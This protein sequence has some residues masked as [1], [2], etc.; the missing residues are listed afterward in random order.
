M[1]ARAMPRPQMPP[2]PRRQTTV[3]DIEAQVLRHV[4][5]DPARA[6]MIYRAAAEQVGRLVG[7][8]QNA[9]A[10]EEL[11]ALAQRFMQQSTSP[12]F[13]TSSDFDEQLHA[14]IEG[15]SL[16]APNDLELVAY[17][18][19]LDEAQATP[20]TSISPES[21][22]RDT[23]LGR[24]S[25]FKYA[26]TEQEHALGV[27]QEDTLVVW[28]G[29]KHEAQAFTVDFSLANPAPFPPVPDDPGTEPIYMARPYGFVE[30]G[31]DGAKTR[32]LFDIGFGT[33]FTVV[34]NY[35]A[36]GAGMYAPPEAVDD[37]P[38][39]LSATLRIGCSIGAFA[40]P[41]VSPVTF[42]GYVDRLANTFQS[43]PIQRPVKGTYLLPLLCD[44]GAGST[45]IDFLDFNAKLLYQVVWNGGTLAASPIPLS[46][47]VAYVQ[48]L[49]GTGDTANYR[50]VFQLAL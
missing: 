5:A 21:F 49:N 30:Y 31:S 18:Q 42:T 45:N 19:Q 6:P 3:G 37:D 35:I 15:Y 8:P 47:D 13:G 29:L 40:A 16:G 36:A 20:R 24:Y 7:D 12:P 41:S 1:S 28:P 4:Q 44:I 48:L 26:P 14:S 39:T 34:G 23:A 27:R 11:H 32:V 17:R 46:P 43:D 50:V 25:L 2:L 33:R 10:R 9:R 38:E 22:T